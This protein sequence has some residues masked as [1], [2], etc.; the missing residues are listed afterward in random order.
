MLYE[1]ITEAFLRP[2]IRV[3]YF[4]PSSRAPALIRAIHSARHLLGIING[5]LDLSKAEAGRLTLD[6]EEVAID[7]VFDQCLRLFREKASVITSYSIHYTKLYETTIRTMVRL[8]D[9]AAM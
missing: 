6:E 1:V 9:A 7:E 5:V 3:L 4:M 8:A 2:F